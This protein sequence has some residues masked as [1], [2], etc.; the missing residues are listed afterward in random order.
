MSAK[1]PFGLVGATIE[2][3]Y[4][5]LRVVGEGG[6]GVVYAARHQVL[7]SEVAVKVLKP[8]GGT[9]AEQ[10]QLTDAFL[11]EARV[12]FTLS[13]RAI[14]RFY[15]AGTVQVGVNAL[16]YVVLELLQGHT[17]EDEIQRRIQARAH[18]G[19]DEIERIFGPVLE[20]LTLA[21]EAGIVHRDLKPANIMLV[22]GEGGALAPKILDFGTA[23][24]GPMHA[25]TTQVAFTPRYA[26]PEQWDPTYGVTGAWTDVFALGATLYEVCTLAA[27][28]PGDG[29]GQIMRSSLTFR[30]RLDVTRVRPDLPPAFGP[31]LA[32]SVAAQPTERAGELLMDPSF[33]VGTK[34]YTVLVS[35][36][37]ILT[38]TVGVA[39]A[40]AGAWAG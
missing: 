19:K 22:R 18:F 9:V 32:R 25:S 26:A 20:A 8:Q 38:W 15:E 1:D 28:L 2:G 39:A 31:M 29:V 11:R 37:G 7:G 5:L 12:L 30:E 13:H 3:K 33:T 35:N 21:H 36:L 4:A 23:R 24:A 27:A 40:V 17:L 16:P 34:W 6:F 10:Q 14:V